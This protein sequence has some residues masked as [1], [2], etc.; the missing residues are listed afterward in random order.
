M[1]SIILSTRAFLCKRRVGCVVSSLILVDKCIL[2]FPDFL[3]ETVSFL[4]VFEFSF[5][6]KICEVHVFTLYYFHPIMGQKFSS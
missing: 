4:K 6:H 3:Y 5:E 1:V 2:L